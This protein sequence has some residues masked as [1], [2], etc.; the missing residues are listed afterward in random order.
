MVV[1]GLPARAR[2]SGGSTRQRLP[3]MHATHTHMPSTHAW[4]LACT[5]RFGLHTYGRQLLHLENCQADR[6]QRRQPPPPRH[7]R[8]A[9]CVAPAPAPAPAFR[10]LVPPRRLYVLQQQDQ[11]PHECEAGYYGF[12]S[13]TNAQHRL[14]LANTY[15]LSSMLVRPEQQDGAAATPSPPPA[16]AE[17]GAA[18]GAAAAVV[19]VAKPP[20]SASRGS[21]LRQAVW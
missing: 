3:G 20:A 15:V 10:G 11:L 17:E 14:V 12:T 19:A 2:A 6:P 9:A 13:S 21:R 4:P 1:R 7:A 5:T 18:Q 8:Q 16:G